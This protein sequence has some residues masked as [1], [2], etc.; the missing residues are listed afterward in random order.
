LENISP[1]G[2]LFI[3]LYYAI[4][5]SQA[6]YGNN[7]RSY[8]LL[9]PVMPSLLLQAARGINSGSSCWQWRTIIGPGD[10][11]SAMLPLPASHR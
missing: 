3:R 11:R 4:T 6:A 8:R 2:I 1:N 7:D 5:T 9:T 10:V